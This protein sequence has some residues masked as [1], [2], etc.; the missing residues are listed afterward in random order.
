MIQ[1]SGFDEFHKKIVEK[2]S[3]FTNVREEDNEEDEDEEEAI[4]KKAFNGINH[5]IDDEEMINMNFLNFDKKLMQMQED[6]EEDNE[7]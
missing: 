5:D 4:K 7:N 1:E 2:E 3:R 6:E